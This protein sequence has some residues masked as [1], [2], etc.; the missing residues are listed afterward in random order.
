LTSAKVICFI[1]KLGDWCSE[2]LPNQEVFLRISLSPAPDVARLP[3]LGRV[4][5]WA[6]SEKQEVDL[7]IKAPD[8]AY[9]QRGRPQ[10]SYQGAPRKL[11]VSA[12]GWRQ[13]GPKKNVMW[14]RD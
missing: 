8:M 4:V 1:K 6:L 14:C 12:V 3:S 7:D 9:G 10:G 13:L 2:I 11:S 5:G